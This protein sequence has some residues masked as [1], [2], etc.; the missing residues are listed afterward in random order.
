MLPYIA[1]IIGIY[2][3]FISNCVGVPYFSAYLVNCPGSNCPGQLRR[4]VNLVLV[5]TCIIYM[6]SIM[7]LWV[8]T[9]G[10]RLCVTDST[11]FPYSPDLEL[12][13]LLWWL[14]EV[15]FVPLFTGLGHRRPALVTPRSRLCS[16]IHRTWCSSVCSC[17]SLKSTMLSLKS[18]AIRTV[19]HFEGVGQQKFA[20]Y[21]TLRGSGQQKCAQYI[22]LRGRAG[23]NAHSTSL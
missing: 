20:Q 15:D 18:A 7:I 2:R 13:G 9:G 11:L 16:L 6:I 21:I 22:T 23:R 10:T 19:H 8:R 14:P 17:E 4:Y 5:G 12:V 1:T 3:G